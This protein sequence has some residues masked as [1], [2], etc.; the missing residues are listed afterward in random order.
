MGKLQGKHIILG[1]TSSA[2]AYKACEL[3]R[4]LI[5]AGAELRVVMTEHA[6]ELIR[7]L[8]FETLTGKRVYTEM[9][10]DERTEPMEHISLADWGDLFL[11]APATANF[12]GKAA[13]GVADDLLSTTYLTVDVPII[14]APAMND[15]MWGDASVKANVAALRERGVI[16]VGPGTGELACGTSGKG[17]LADLE[18]IIA[19]VEEILVKPGPLTGKTVLVTAGPT[20]E[21]IDEVRFLSNPSTGRMGF[22]LASAA[23]DFGAE[24]ILIH[25]PSH[26]KPPENA[27]C[28][29]TISAKEMADAVKSHYD[30]ADIVIMTAAVADWTPIKYEGKLKKTGREKLTLELSPTEDILDGLGKNKGNRLLMGFAVETEDCI[31]NARQKLT[32]KNLDIVFVNNPREAGAAFGTTTNSGHLITTDGEEEIPTTD[33]DNLA[34]IIIKRIIA[35]L[36]TAGK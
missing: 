9:F 17:R 4:L 36:E 23:A 7:P 34:R 25:G 35:L 33:K 29:S 30:R 13:S 16:I 32:A 10:P 26:L 28:I 1:V 11:I 19:A 6:T 21:Y 14:V 18:E 24:V 12:I 5:K 31:T 27:L 22:A 2:A 15:R 20:R 8:L 3:A